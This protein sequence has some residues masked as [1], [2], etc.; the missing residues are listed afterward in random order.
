MTVA[1]LLHV[2]ILMFI[3]GLAFQV[4]YGLLTS[5]INMRGLFLDKSGSGVVRPERIQL[6]IVTI[7][8]AAR[9]LGEVS[10]SVTP[11]F[12]TIDVGW[13]YVFGGSNGVY[14]TRKLVERFGAS[15]RQR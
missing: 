6:L 5:R 14:V 9:Y 3:Y 13:L 10:V 11:A 1:K 8:L 4:A 7:A 12:P 15:R 2:E